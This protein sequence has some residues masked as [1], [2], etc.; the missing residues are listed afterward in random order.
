MSQFTSTFVT[1]ITCILATPAIARPALEKPNVV[2]FFVDDSGYGDYSHNGNPTIS[3][4]HISKLSQEGVNFTQFYVSTAACSASR[5]ALLTGRYPARSGLGSWVIGPQAPRYIHPKELTLAESFKAAGYTTGMFGKWHLGTPNKK[6]KFTPDA[7]PLA[8]GF[9]TW[10]GTNVSHD[11]AN[12]MLIKSDPNGNEPAKGYSI[13]AKNLPK[14]QNASESLV[15]RYTKGA[16]DFIQQH[17]DKPFF[18]YIAHNQPHLSLFRSDPFKGVSRR[19]MLGD[20][21][22]EVDDSVGQVTEAIEKAGIA[23]NTLIIYASDNGPWVSHLNPKTRHVGYA[24]PFR[25]GKGSTWEGGFRVPGIFYWPG[26]IKPHSIVQS[27]AS[28][29]DVFPTLMHLIGGKIPSDRSMD[30]RDITA[31]LMEGEK[32]EKSVKP[33]EFLYSYYDNMPSGLRMGP[34]KLMPR[35]GSQLQKNYGFNASI[36]NPLLFQVEEDLHET[37]NQANIHPE[38]VAK[39]KKVYLEKTKQLISEGNFWNLPYPKPKK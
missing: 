6:N 17:K 5:F 25:D 37:Y 18:L 34:W 23:K 1:L 35:I 32:G 10:I 33:F 22:A 3:T 8:H 15:G 14:N 36:K 4:P 31:Y 19:G 38:T 21:M 7:L 20:V 27:P 28:T 11:Y 26:T 13:I 24:Y 9:D 12:S 29:L 16:V 39:M 2:L 30:G